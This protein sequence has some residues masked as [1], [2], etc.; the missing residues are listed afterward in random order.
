MI[1]NM[2]S[3]Q[4]KKIKQGPMLAWFF[5]NL[6]LFISVFDFDHTF[7]FLIFL[8][9]KIYI[10]YHFKN[11]KIIYFSFIIII[12]IKILRTALQAK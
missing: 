8:S 10:A 5:G 3:F 2:L 4:L 12:I 7:F 6:Y 11:S 1:K 9:I